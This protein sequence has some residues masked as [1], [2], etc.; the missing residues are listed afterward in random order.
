M[1]KMEAMTEI[2]KIKNGVCPVHGLIGADGEHLGFDF[3]SKSHIC[4][5]CLRERI[6]GL[7]DAY[8]YLLREHDDLFGMWNNLDDFVR[9]LGLSQEEIAKI[10]AK[11]DEN[12]RRLGEIFSKALRVKE[13]VEDDGG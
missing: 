11:V 6:E 12:R 3:A 13:A 4:L 5:T 2:G 9:A 7:E 10:Y 1:I 8:E